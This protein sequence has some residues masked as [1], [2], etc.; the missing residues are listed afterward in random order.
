MALAPAL[1]RL[2][3]LEYLDIGSNPLG[4]EGLIALV[5]PPS[6]SGA[7]SPPAGV[8]TKLEY[9]DLSG[10]KITDA[11]CAAF[12]AALESGALP[13]FENLFLW[14]IPASAAAKDAVYEARNKLE[15]EEDEEDDEDD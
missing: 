15:G 2:P 4:D 10:T 14:G 9:L 6:P 1:R 3:A 12:A 5:A 13:A 11:G 7:L 8:L